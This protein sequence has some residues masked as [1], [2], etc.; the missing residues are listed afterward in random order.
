MIYSALIGNP[1]KHSISP[2]LFTLLAEKI[3]INYAHIKIKI[4]EQ[5]KLREVMESFVSLNFVGLNIT[6]PYKM[7]I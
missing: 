1:V 7:E 3:N 2:Y 4:G 5:E 6:C